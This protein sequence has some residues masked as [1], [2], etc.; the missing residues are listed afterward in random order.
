MKRYSGN[1]VALL[2]GVVLASGWFGTA[3]VGAETL[4]EA[5]L[6]AYRSNPVL[7]SDR[8]RQRATD[9]LVPTAKSGWRP[10]IIANGAALRTW[11]DTDVTKAD[12]HSSVQ[13]DIQLSQPIFRGFKTVEGIKSAKAQVRA[14]RQQ[15]LVTEQD[16]LLDAVT[17]YMDVIRDARILALRNRNVTNLRKQVDAA[18][19][20]F[21]AGEVT[22]TDVSQARARLAAAEAGV[23]T[24][25]AD[26]NAS[27]AAYAA[28]IGHAP[29][30]LANARSAKVPRTLDGALNTAQQV[31]PNILGADA[32][33]EAAV[34]D[35]E[36]AKGDLLPEIS[37]EA[38]ASKD[39]HPQRG[40][41]RSESAS[42]AGV[43]SV[44]IYQGGQEYSAVRRQKQ[45][46]N[47]RQI[48]VVTATRGV[49]QQ[50]TTAW[51]FLRAAGDSI[52]SARAQIPVRA[53]G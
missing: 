22:T 13:L 36:V 17:A 19:A 25:I 28:V 21:D 29:G 34:H 51:H 30:K 40:V 46:A 39:F 48:E 47:Q 23:A 31:N 2:V 43:I 41:D 53:S 12:A 42:I 45:T 3:P 10:V 26:L 8:A 15:L 24:A 6:S 9:E 4:Q 32:L 35:I 20:R 7:Q 18:V 5:L 27:K 50:V 11:S 37:L 38:Q 44:P 16:V 52:V 33:R 49:R 1:K 14:G